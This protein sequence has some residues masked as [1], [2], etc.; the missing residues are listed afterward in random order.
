MIELRW[1][2]QDGPGYTRPI[3]QY[4]LCAAID[5]N[6]AYCPG[7]AGAWTDVPRVT[8]PMEPDER[9]NCCDGGPQYGHAW[10]C[11]NLPG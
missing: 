11:P 2:I 3:L 6:G 7:I 4:R 9:R 8:V 10:D 5:M 1:K